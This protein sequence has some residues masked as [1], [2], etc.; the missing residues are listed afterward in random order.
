MKQLGFLKK[1]NWYKGN[2]HCHSVIS[3]GNENTD[4]LIKIYLEK[5]YNFL[6]VTDH[7]I[8]SG[9]ELAKETK[10]I[11]LIPAVEGSAYLIE[12]EAFFAKSSANLD[13]H[14]LNI[15]WDEQ[16]NKK[17]KQAHHI[18][19]FLGT[20]KMQ[21]AAIEPMLR[22]GELITPPVFLHEWDGREVLQ[23]IV[24]Y[25]RNRGF[26][27]SYNHP[28]WSKI[29]LD[30]VSGV[31]GIWSVEIYNHSTHLGSSNGYDAFFIDAMAAEGNDIKIIATDDNHN[32]DGDSDCFGG[33]V[34]VCAEDCTHDNIVTSLLE[35]NFYS[36]SG[37]EIIDWGIEKNTAFIECEDCEWIRF[38]VDGRVGDGRTIRRQD[39]ELTSASY[40]LQ[41]YEKSIRIECM[42][43]SGKMAWTNFARLRE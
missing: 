7:D 32:V 40:Q 25:F 35:G 41:G 12:D 29:K 18:N 11:L 22:R 6:A 37:C 24:D 9:E 17:C 5:G 10:D 4:Q 31:S 30:Q 33:Y 1:G 21:E 43:T 2:M 8:Y 34:M 39:R 28:T 15:L 20:S 26:F 36:S 16:K 14:S 38:V 13:R 42:N 3:D 19:A 27:I 23:G